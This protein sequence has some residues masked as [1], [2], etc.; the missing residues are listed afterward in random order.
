[1]CLLAAN[2]WR[3]SSDDPRGNPTVRA[4]LVALPIALAVAGVGVWIFLFRLNLPIPNYAVLLPLSLIAGG[5]ASTLQ[6]ARAGWRP[7]AFGL[8]L[9]VPLVCAYG[10]VA[11]AGRGT[12]CP[13]RGTRPRRSPAG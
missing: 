1:M 9:I 3:R 7:P 11:A 6:T 2:A 10:T 12:S 5:V 4:V 13:T 8:W